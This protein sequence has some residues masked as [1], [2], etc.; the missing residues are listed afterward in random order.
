MI[1]EL[2]IGKATEPVQANTDGNQEI[3]FRGGAED[4]SGLLVDHE[5]LLRSHVA[6]TV[7]IFLA[8]V[9]DL[10]S[11]FRE[12]A[13]SFV[14]WEVL[15]PLVANF[16]NSIFKAVLIDFALE[17]D[18]LILCVLSSTEFW[19]VPELSYEGV[20]LVAAEEAESDRL[21]LL[22]RF[23]CQGLIVWVLNVPHGLLLPERAL[24]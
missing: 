7:F 9:A 17:T 13:E 23:R 21:K 12:K 15:L 3:V 22:I 11:V 4:T 20:L 24:L 8:D 2:E 16:S 10:F 5:V 1:D 18:T 6:L 14:E 19:Q